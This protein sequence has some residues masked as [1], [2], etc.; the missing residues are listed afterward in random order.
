VDDRIVPG[1]GPYPPQVYGVIEW[2]MAN[3]PKFGPMEQLYLERYVPAELRPFVA[4]GQALGLLSPCGHLRVTRLGVT[5]LE[6]RPAEPP[7]P[8]PFAGSPAQQQL[9]ALLLKGEPLTRDT[10]VLALDLGSGREGRDALRKLLG[11]YEKTLGAARPDL[12]LMATR[13]RR[14]T[15]GAVRLRQK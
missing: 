3:C 13:G 10:L 4:V 14:G 7:A 11:R 6:L 1:V 5:A 8:D 9:H 15:P 2:L 12:R